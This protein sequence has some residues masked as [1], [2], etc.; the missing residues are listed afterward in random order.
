MKRSTISVTGSAEARGVP[1]QFWPEHL[2]DLSGAEIAIGGLKVPGDYFLLSGDTSGDGGGPALDD[3]SAHAAS[4]LSPMELAGGASP[5][6]SFNT[7]VC[8]AEVGASGQPELQTEEGLSDC[9]ASDVALDPAVPSENGDIAVLTV[10]PRPAVFF[11]AG[12]GETYSST[13]I[14]API[15]AQVPHGTSVRGFDAAAAY[16]AD[17]LVPTGI[18]AHQAQNSGPGQG[19]M[20]GGGA[21]GF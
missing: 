1:W 17:I 11:A 7:P 15:P 5:K 19:A 4:D 12:S 14:A 6:A 18:A 9:P 10:A 2:C 21:P 8:S 3:V 20:D 13:P 16:D